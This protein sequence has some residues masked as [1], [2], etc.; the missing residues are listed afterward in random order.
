[1][2]GEQWEER[3]QN[4][5][6]KYNKLSLTMM[7]CPLEIVRDIKRVTA[8]LSLWYRMAMITLGLR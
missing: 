6:R 8:S 4:R 2:S 5:E 7:D 3:W 1:M